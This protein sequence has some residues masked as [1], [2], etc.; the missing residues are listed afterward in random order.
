MTGNGNHTTYLWWFGGWFVIVWP[1]L[2]VWWLK[3]ISDFAFLTLIFG[4]VKWY[5]L[6]PF[7]EGAVMFCGTQ[8]EHLSLPKK[9]TSDKWLKM[10]KVK[11]CSHASVWEICNI[12]H[13]HAWVQSSHFHSRWTQRQPCRI[14]KMKKWHW[15]RTAFHLCLKETLGLWDSWNSFLHR[16]SQSTL[17]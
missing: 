14:W 9:W 13:W 10:I 16:S 7:R 6:R 4:W 2:R 11:W 12:K 5:I 3:S 17:W 8:T 1:I 15:A